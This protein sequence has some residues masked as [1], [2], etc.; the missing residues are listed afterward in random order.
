[1]VGTRADAQRFVCES[2]RVQRFP[3][4]ARQ[5]VLLEALKKEGYEDSLIATVLTDVSPGALNKLNYYPEILVGL[6]A[7]EEGLC[8]PRFPLGFDRSGPEP[9]CCFGLPQNSEKGTV[10]IVYSHCPEEGDIKEFVKKYRCVSFGRP[11]K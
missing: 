5:D 11:P 8:S 4:V 2:I 7:K 6:E 3:K 9:I 1:M 10:E